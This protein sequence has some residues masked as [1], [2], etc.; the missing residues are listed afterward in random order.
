ME[1]GIVLRIEF[2]A[3]AQASR[4]ARAANESFDLT[5]LPT[6]PQAGDVLRL[7]AHQTDLDYYVVQR[8]FD[9]TARP[10][11]V[12]LALDLPPRSLSAV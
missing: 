11:V 10:P 1:A 3:R 2:T 5:A 9:L 4:Q 8:R 7:P 12:C 6:L